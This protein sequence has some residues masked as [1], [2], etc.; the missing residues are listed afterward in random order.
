MI[1][2][3]VNFPNIGFLKI[4]LDENKIQPIISEVNEI[5]KNFLSATPANNFL[6]GNIK[7]EFKIIKSLDHIAVIIA[8]AIKNYNKN[9]NFL[10]KNDF[11]SSNCPM[12]IN[13][14]WVNFQEK[15]EFNPTH[16]HAGI[17]SFVFWLKIPYNIDSE[18]LSSPGKHSSNP[19]AGHFSFHYTNS[20]GQICHY[21]IPADNTMENV[22]L[23][24]PAK[25]NHSVYPFYSSD[26]YRISVSGNVVFQV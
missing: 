22:L 26:D 18:M 12:I 16:D 7:K 4:K 13:H 24:F 1:I 8:E 20:L 23:V 17:F 14:A 19:L 15:H 21:D 9:F 5:Q 10:V 2:E 6:V 3:P 11:L 25:L